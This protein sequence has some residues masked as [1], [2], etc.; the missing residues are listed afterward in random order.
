MRKLHQVFADYIDYNL[1]RSIA[2]W[3][4]EQ[5]GR[6]AWTSSSERFLESVSTPTAEASAGE[7]AVATTAESRTAGAGAGS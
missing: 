2:I 1:K 5:H 4:I 7:A 6:A 3:A